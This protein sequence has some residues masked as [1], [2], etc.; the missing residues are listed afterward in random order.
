MVGA[1]G[2]M[3]KNRFIGISCI[4]LALCLVVGI[5]IILDNK[6]AVKLSKINNNQ[7]SIKYPN[8]STVISDINSGLVF[9]II[10]L[11]K[12]NITPIKITQVP[13]VKPDKS[14]RPTAKASHAPAPSLDKIVKLI[15]KDKINNPIM[16]LIPLFIFVLI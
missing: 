11:I 6:L 8:R 5:S 16:K 15:P 14:E 4:V 3:K 1:I 9:K 13:T 2:Y 12:I 7:K 10:A